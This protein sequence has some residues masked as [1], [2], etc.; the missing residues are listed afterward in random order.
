MNQK[1]FIFWNNHIFIIFQKIGYK[2]IKRQS[3][4][5]AIKEHIKISISHQY[6]EEKEKSLLKKTLN[7]RNF[8]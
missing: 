7:L 6:L 1:L 4:Y 5:T 2:S 8:S 3:L